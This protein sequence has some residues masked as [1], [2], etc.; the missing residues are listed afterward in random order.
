MA[1]NNGPGKLSDLRDLRLQRTF[2]ANN[3][4]HFSWRQM[5]LVLSLEWGR[6]VGKPAWFVQ[7]SLQ[8]HGSQV[9]KEPTPCLVLTER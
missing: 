3:I 8:T 9:S 6:Q 5:V 1:D 7:G 2:L 4:Y